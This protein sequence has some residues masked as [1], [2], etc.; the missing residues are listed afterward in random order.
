MTYSLD[1]KSKRNKIALLFVA[2]RQRFHWIFLSASR[3]VV[4]FALTLRILKRQHPILILSK[5][6]FLN[7]SNSCLRWASQQ[8]TKRELL[9]NSKDQYYK[10]FS[11]LHWRPLKFW[12]I[13][14][15]R[16]KLPSTEKP[17]VLAKKC[18][19]IGPFRDCWHTG[20][21]DWKW[22]V[23]LICWDKYYKTSFTITDSSIFMQDEFTP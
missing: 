10:L 19:K 8:L 15:S 9:L 21:D 17:S 5:N 18:Y 7:L 23:L 16:I 11:S 13:K 4:P 20:Q 12:C 22:E 3:C 6:F 14:L 2:T 1:C